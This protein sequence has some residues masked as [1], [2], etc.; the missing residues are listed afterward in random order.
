MFWGKWGRNVK[1]CFRD[2]QKAHPCAWPVFD[3]S[4]V[5]GLTQHWLMTITPTG[6]CKVWSGGSDLTLHHPPSLRK[7][8]NPNSSLNPYEL[9]ENAPECTILIYKKN[10]NCQEGGIASRYGVK[11]LHST[12]YLSNMWAERSIWRVHSPLS[13]LT[14]ITNM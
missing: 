9:Y 14:G 6:D 1:F 7:V 10:K 4:R 12:V 8:Q 13:D 3:L 5:G 2:P 11:C